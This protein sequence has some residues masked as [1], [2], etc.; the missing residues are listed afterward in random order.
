MSNFHKEIP[1]LKLLGVGSSETRALKTN[2]LLALQELGLNVVIEEIQE[3]EKLMQYDIIGIPALSLDG[4]VLLQKQVP[5]V[6]SLK[7]MLE[8][9]FN[10]TSNGENF[11]DL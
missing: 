8:L 5:S 10:H 11:G 4:K 1:R 6:E 7:E 9:A 3:F 2:L